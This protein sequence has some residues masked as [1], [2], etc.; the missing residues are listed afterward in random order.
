MPKVKIDYKKVQLKRLKRSDKEKLGEFIG[1]DLSLA[2]DKRLKHALSAFAGDE[3]LVVGLFYN[4]NDLIAIAP[5]FVEGDDALIQAQPFCL[6]AL[7]DSDL[8][9]EAARLSKKFV[10]KMRPGKLLESRADA[11][12]ATTSAT[13]PRWSPALKRPRFRS[14]SA[15]A[16]HSRKVLTLAPRQPTTGVS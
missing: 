6:S 7:A 5:F 3:A 8:L 13:A 2:A 4:K 16:R 1:R 11:K 9:D 15:L 14:C 10:Q 12:K